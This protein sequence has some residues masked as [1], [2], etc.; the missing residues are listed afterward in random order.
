MYA[1]FIRA[2]RRDQSTLFAIR[3][4]EAKHDFISVWRLLAAPRYYRQDI[5]RK[6]NLSCKAERAIVSSLSPSAPADALAAPISRVLGLVRSTARAPMLSLDRAVSSAV[7]LHS[8]VRFL[9]S[10]LSCSVLLLMFIRAVPLPLS[11]IWLC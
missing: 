7:A 11:H 8:F 3:N 10:M 2:R 6:L 5:R 9:Y 1:V 4:G